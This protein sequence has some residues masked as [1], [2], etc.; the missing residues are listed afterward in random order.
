MHMVLCVIIIRKRCEIVSEN[1]ST[2]F[3]S[4]FIIKNGISKIAFTY[5]TQSTSQFAEVCIDNKVSFV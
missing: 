2:L 1:L 3:Q 4:F 5:S